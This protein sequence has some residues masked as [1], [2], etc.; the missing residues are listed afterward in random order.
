MYHGFTELCHYMTKKYPGYI[1]APLR[2][3][4]SGIES[5]F[6]SLKYIARGHLASTNYCTTLGSLITQKETTC[7]VNPNAEKGYRT[8]SVTLNQ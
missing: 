7:T 2:V 4:G 1:V 5:V 3:N 6:S 8:V